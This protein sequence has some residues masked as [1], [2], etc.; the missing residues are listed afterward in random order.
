MRVDEAR[1]AELERWARSV[2]QES[3]S[4]DA[5]AA[6]RAI[7]LLLDD[8]ER[9]ER[10]LEALQSAE[11]A[12]TARR[13]S[14]RGGAVGLVAVGVVSAAA[15]LGARALAP[16]LAAAGPDQGARIG[17]AAAQRLAFSVEADAGTLARVRWRVDG[18]D[19]TS[20]AHVSRGRSVLR[21]SDL[22]DGEHRV[23]AVVPRR[24][25]HLAAGRSWHVSIDR[26]PP[27]VHVDPASA[28]APRG[29]PVTLRGTV[30]PGSAVTADG[31]RAAMRGGFFEVSLAAPPQKAVE[32]VAT[33]RYGNSAR[34]SVTVAVVPRTPS[35]PTRAVHVSFYGWADRGLR[36]GVM[37]LVDEGRID[38]V[39]LDLK[40]ESGVVGFDADIPFARRIGSVRRIYD[41]EQA[42]E[43]LH[44]KGVLVIGRIVAFRDPVHAE[45]A[46]KR[47]W[48]SQV[49]QTPG[50]GPYSGYGGFTNF[51]DPV[52]RQYNID[53]ARRAAE[54]GVDDILYDYVRRPDG[55]IGTM[56]FP[57]L[58]G[59]P[60]AA[61]A[62]FLGEAQSQLRPF[63][64][65]LGA[66]VFGVAAT[67][68]KEIGQ[69]I[70]AIARN[71]DYV[72]PMVYPS[73]WSPGEYDVPSPNSQPYDIV[74][75]SLADF[76][77]QTRG[78]GARVVP[79]L[80]DFTLGVT[81]GPAEVRAQI[82]AAADRG[83]HEWLLWDPLVTY[84]ADALDR[85]PKRPPIAASTP[86]AQPPPPRAAAAGRR[87]NELGLVPVIMHHQIR[88]DGGG[89]YDLTPA[90]FRAELERLHREGYVPI[91]AED[92]VSGKIDIPAGKSPVVLTFDDS[93]KEQLAWDGLKRA[94]PD[95]AVGIMLAFARTHPG[96]RPAGT[97][98]VNR[99][100]FAGVREG[101]EMLRWLHE[102]GFELG[103]HTYD[104][105]PFSQLTP[106]EVQREL[107][108]GKKLIVD[109][110]PGAAV[111]TIALPL[112]V[113]PKPARLARAGTWSGISYHHAGVFL[114]GAE[115]AP[116]PFSS[117]FEPAAVPRIRTSPPGAR[118][119]DF[120]S[121]YWLDEL[122]RH[123]ER[124][125]VSDGDPATIS[126]PRALSDTLAP[127]FRSRSRPY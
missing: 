61:I 100:P 46:W 16:D 70:R 47:G 73:H 101:D 95:T 24:L 97:F 77:R 52:V 1:R 6:A 121:T 54:A 71:V 126:F 64:V 87:A 56:I 79:W 91:R 3:E 84:T 36:A 90:Q 123:R 78:T 33:D 13:F 68:P 119:G 15:A 38:A 112:G 69:P 113:M 108:L 82:K 31:R 96:F 2:A 23:E 14:R 59:T 80:Q 5:R 55:P 28:Q 25:P 66:S 58:R 83:I 120:G 40:D 65:F 127:R 7:A 109:A 44:R 106:R 74:F 29:R 57:G 72:A 19:V 115:P 114:V 63:D 99:E 21:G 60:E 118:D 89:D 105:V 41:L 92:L 49:V 76:R 43:L 8:V 88:A 9:L 12:P 116:S 75:R 94:K 30:E 98:Y 102:N 110:V 111:T 51:A 62:S 104:H 39:Q 107:A 103:N 50:G 81:Y 85:H 35:A 20:R 11:P 18:A 48:K 34:K 26:T 93:T 32:L 125:Y 37:R 4:A 124:R 17:A 45:A 22:P 86:P 122:R 117:S 27:Q 53:I 10:E 42:V 67:R